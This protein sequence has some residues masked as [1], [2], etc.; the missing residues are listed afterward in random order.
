MFKDVYHIGYRTRDKDAAIAFY[1]EALGA[2][3]KLEA[4][5]ADGAKLAF[6]RLGET[7]VEL[8]Q[9]ADVGELRD[10]PLLVLDHVGYVVD[11]VEDGLAEL[12]AKGMKRQFVRT[13]AEGARIAYIEPSTANGLKFHL[14]ERPT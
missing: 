9:P 13:N 14:T 2:E 5:N 1:K 3:L 6:L 12:E 8:I 10:G 11:S 4:N 7:E